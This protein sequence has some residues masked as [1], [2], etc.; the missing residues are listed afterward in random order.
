METIDGQAMQILG[1]L[2]A[3]ANLTLEQVKKTNGR[4]TSLEERTGKLELENVATQAALVALNAHEAKKGSFW[5]RWLDRIL[6]ALFTGVLMLG[7]WVLIV[8]GII[9]VPTI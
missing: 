1:R 8:T 9:H 7:F 4:V 2:E 3:T 6:D 5:D